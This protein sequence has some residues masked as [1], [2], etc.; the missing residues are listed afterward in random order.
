MTP[1]RRGVL[2]SLAAALF[3][4]FPLG[5]V[6]Q[7]TRAQAGNNSAS[8]SRTGKVSQGPAQSVPPYFKSAA[9]AKPLPT[10]LP[11]SRFEGR[12]VVVRAYEIANQIPEVLAQEP[13]YCTCDQN[14]GHRSLLDCYASDH[15]AGCPVC[16]KEAFLAYEMTNQGKKAAAIRQA[17]V[18][19][20][21]KKVNLL[22]PPSLTP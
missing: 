7:S 11:P 13:C 21:W 10:L 20:D 12:P 18:R 9:A 19:G 6:S 14:F 1:G 5:G 15:T 4:C 22:H 3:L 8:E 2:L 16:V 17:I